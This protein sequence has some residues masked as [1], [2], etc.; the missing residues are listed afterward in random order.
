MRQFN[1]KI[2]R[3]PSAIFLIAFGSIIIFSPIY[4]LHRTDRCTACHQMQYCFDSLKKSHHKGLNC[5]KCHNKPDMKTEIGRL[6]GKQCANTENEVRSYD[7]KCLSCHKRIETKVSHQGLTIEHVKHSDRK[8]PCAACHQSAGHKSKTSVNKPH[9]RY[10][11]QCHQ[12]YCSK[13]HK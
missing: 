8:V 11:K 2:L 12:D 1:P 7:Q 3:R 6:R 9:T 5:D 13:C 4:V 10:C